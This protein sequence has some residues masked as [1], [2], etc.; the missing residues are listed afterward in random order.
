MANIIIFGGS[1]DPVHNGHLKIALEAYEHLGGKVVFVPSKYPRWKEPTAQAEHRLKMLKIAIK[2]YS[3]F[4]QVDDLEMNATKNPNYTIDTLRIFKERY[5]NDN[6]YLLIGE[7]QV[8]KFHGWKDPDEI[9]ALAKVIYYGRNDSSHTHV[10]ENVR[11]YQMEHLEGELSNTSSTDIREMRSVDLP[12]FVL[13][14]ILDHDLYFS[15][16]VHKYYSYERY[17]HVCSSALTACLIAMMNEDVHIDYYKAFVASYL[18]DLGKE[19]KSNVQE[20]IMMTK[21]YEFN[22]IPSYAWHQFVGRYLA[23]K[24]FYIDDE[25]ILNAIEYHCTG[26]ANM[27][28]LEKV[29]YC[30][31]KI[32]PTRDYDTREMLDVCNRDIEEGFLFV[33]NENKKHIE[34]KKNK[35]AINRL[36]EECFAYYL[37]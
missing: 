29:V 24:D 4:F 25:D 28:L 22:D 13:K 37:K 21:F 2:P 10:E 19:V 18:H 35:G 16:L 1:F 8:N 34:S 12:L 7:D 23:M 33:L 26:R 5:P 32:E 17:R 30:A 31:D 36:S 20:E 6:L 11:K 27:S 15:K 14:Y 3:S 9:I